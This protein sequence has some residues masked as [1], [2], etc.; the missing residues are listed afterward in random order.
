ML[1]QL[2]I[3]CLCKIYS[4]VNRLGANTAVREPSVTL[5]VWQYLGEA[6]ATT[7]G[8][9]HRVTSGAALLLQRHG[10]VD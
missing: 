4:K 6:V 10:L 2:I 7:D 1:R 3:L 5:E 9:L 8:G